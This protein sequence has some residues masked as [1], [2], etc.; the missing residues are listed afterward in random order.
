M[1]LSGRR[2]RNPKLKF[3]VEEMAGTLN[4]VNF[5]KKKNRNK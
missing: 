1:P 5:K 2:W 4:I 3:I